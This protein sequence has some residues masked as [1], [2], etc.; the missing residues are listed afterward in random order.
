MNEYIGVFF[1]FFVA[2]VAAVVAVAAAASYTIAACL[3][4]C[5]LIKFSWCFFLN[6]GEYT[7]AQNNIMF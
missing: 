4:A 6:E 2:V 5:R 7:H 3:L 1:F